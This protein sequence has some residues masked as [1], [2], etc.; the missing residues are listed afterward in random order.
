MY[1]TFEGGNTYLPPKDFS[2]EVNPAEATYYAPTVPAAPVL[3]KTDTILVTEEAAR[4]AYQ[5]LSK[6]LLNVCNLPRVEEGAVKRLQDIKEKAK[7][8][9]ST[10]VLKTI[11][12]VLRFMSRV[13]WAIAIGITGSI[14]VAAICGFPISAG[15]FSML[16]APMIIKRV[17]LTGVYR[18]VA[19]V[20]E[21]IDKQLE[22]RQFHQEF[23]KD[24][25][26]SQD[27]ADWKKFSNL[28]DFRKKLPVALEKIK[29]AQQVC[30][31]QTY[32]DQIR[33]LNLISDKVDGYSKVEKQ[34][35]SA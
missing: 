35:V 3:V 34:F 33:F 28:N 15:I 1:P 21:K 20:V 10:R 18:L 23:A 16:L 7:K 29:A 9:T 11:A 31:K 8:G 5:D 6:D 22:R 30:E 2:R 32:S 19:V 25:Q 27:V 24:K 4:L 26:L 14:G 13:S 12:K 17:V